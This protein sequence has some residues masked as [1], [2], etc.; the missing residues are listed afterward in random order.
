MSVVNEE[1]LGGFYVGVYRFF[2]FF[3]TLCFPVSRIDFFFGVCVCM[4]VSFDCA[5]VSFL[6]NLWVSFRTKLMSFFVLLQ[7]A[8]RDR[9]DGPVL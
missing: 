2:F 3:S 7:Q 6:I 1:G 8:E 4:C 5:P 9:V